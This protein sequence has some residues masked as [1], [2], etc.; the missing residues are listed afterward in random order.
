MIYKPQSADQRP[1]PYS[2]PFETVLPLCFN[3]IYYMESTE[4]EAL[5]H[6]I[7]QYFQQ[8]NPNDLLPRDLQRLPYHFRYVTQEELQPNTLRENLEKKR[9]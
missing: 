3:T 9:N 6:T 8:Q 1:E 2:D 7:Q 5:N 4:N